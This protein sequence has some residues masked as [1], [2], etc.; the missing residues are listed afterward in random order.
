MGFVQVENG[1]FF[2]GGSSMFPRDLR[3][4]SLVL[5][6]KWTLILSPFEGYHLVIYILWY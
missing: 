5:K 6:N 2:C 4:R 1:I 3:D